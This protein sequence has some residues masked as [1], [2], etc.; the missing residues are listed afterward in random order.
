VSDTPGSRRLRTQHDV[1]TEVLGVLQGL[2]IPYMLTGSLAS[3]IHGEP[4]TTLDIDVV[5]DP[6]A[7]VVDR[8]VAELE[9]REYYVDPE[10]ADEAVRNREQFN[11]I[12][13]QGG[14]KVDLIL[15]KDRPFSHAE[16]ARRQPIQ[17]ADITADVTTAED[18]I[19]AKLEWA[20]RGP[21]E[22]QLRDVAGILRAR[23]NELDRDYLAGWV[24]DLGLDEVWERA[25]ALAG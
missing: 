15:R 13:R 9:Q 5:I 19:I 2:G 1:L 11:A 14:W 20:K 24:A 16:F 8:L 17:L 4:R 25:L 23:R 22:R 10:A 12:D 18:T 7:G 6:S 21:S 3:S